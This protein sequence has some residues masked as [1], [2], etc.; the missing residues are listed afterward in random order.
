MNFTTGTF[1]YG[2]WKDK[3]FVAK[4]KPCMLNSNGTVDYYLDPN[5]YTK[6][7]DGTTSDVSNTSYS[8]NAMASIP[9]CWVYRYEDDT[10]E[11]EIVSETQFDSNY[12]AYAHTNSDGSIV[13]YFY[14]SM[15]GGSGNSSKIRSLANKKLCYG[16]NATQ[17][18]NACKSNGSRWFNH[19]WSQRNLIRTL[20]VLMC[21][22]TYTQGCFGNG[23]SRNGTSANDLL[24][25]GTLV[26]K[27]QFYGTSDFKSQV[28]IFH[29]EKFWGDQ[30][31]RISGLV[32]NS[33]S[34]KVF[35]S[36]S[37]KSWINT[38]IKVSNGSGYITKGKVNEY[39]F[40]P[41][42]FTSGSNLLNYYTDAIFS[43]TSINA[44]AA[45]GGC[46]YNANQASGAYALN[47]YADANFTDWDFGCGLSFT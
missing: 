28:K 1:D 33:G 16:L 34:Y 8:G 19:T 38:G 35:P 26:N 37:S 3:W 14:Y 4:N 39:G 17:E 32:S 31:D 41:T 10:Y 5:D 22:S 27:G 20:T 15:F 30:W 9:L 24:T 29:I 11:Y 13:N 42:T 7:E 18:V 2:S 45:C 12:K 6:K 46:E 43:L 21:K 25:T 44:V 23:N 36:L 47:I 40:L